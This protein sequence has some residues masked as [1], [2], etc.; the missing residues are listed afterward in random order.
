MGEQG[1][2]GQAILVI[3]TQC[4]FVKTASNIFVAL[5]RHLRRNW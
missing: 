4:Y 3:V 1:A 2:I 5:I